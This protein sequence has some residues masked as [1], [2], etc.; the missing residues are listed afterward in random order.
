M[1]DFI[2]A[3]WPN[4]KEYQ[5]ADIDKYQKEI[6]ETFALIEQL[7]RNGA[8]A[9]NVVLQL[10]IPADKMPEGAN[11]KNAFRDAFI[12]VAS[13]WSYRHKIY[14]VLHGLIERTVTHESMPKDEFAM[15]MEGDNEHLIAAPK[16]EGDSMTDLVFASIK[17]MQKSTGGNL[18]T[19]ALA[20]LN[21]P[22]MV[23]LIP[24]DNWAPL[25]GKAYSADATTYSVEER[26]TQVA[27]LTQFIFRP[28]ANKLLMAKIVESLLW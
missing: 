7:L 8:D 21:N 25:G 9:E 26:I 24:G 15:I 20:H 3:A 22:T 11:E 27:P 4:A 12:D 28:A 19:G 6:A 14:V 2:W 17:F 1:H 18:N 16:E 10:N 23:T 5:T 13:L